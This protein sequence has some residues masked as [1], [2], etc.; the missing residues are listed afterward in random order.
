MPT[1]SFENIG[2]LQQHL[3]SESPF[4]LLSGYIKTHIFKNSWESITYR[5]V[6]VW[7]KSKI[8][9]VH[10]YLAQREGVILNMWSC[11]WVVILSLADYDIMLEETSMCLRRTE[12]HWRLCCNNLLLN[13][14]QRLRMPLTFFNIFLSVS[15]LNGYNF[16]HVIAPSLCEGEKKTFRWQME[17][18]TYRKDK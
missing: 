16:Y 13:T 2:K 14:T 12:D 4:F 1:K 6:H 5:V 10:I 17:D 3:Y 8:L 15:V 7:A 11:Q 18:V 9:A